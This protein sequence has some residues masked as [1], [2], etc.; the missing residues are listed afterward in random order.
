MVTEEEMKSIALHFFDAG[1]DVT[2]VVAGNNLIIDWRSA[3]EGRTGKV[4]IHTNV[5]NFVRSTL[6]HENE[7]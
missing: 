1:Y 2:S 7:E 6:Y 4:D 5:L 3:E